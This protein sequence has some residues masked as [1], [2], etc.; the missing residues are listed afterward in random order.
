MFSQLT[1]SSLM[2][3]LLTWA[4]NVVLSCDMVDFLETL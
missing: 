1:A 3:S 2:L 4:D